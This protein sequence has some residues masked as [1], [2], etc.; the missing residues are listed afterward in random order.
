[1]LMIR[2]PDKI[3]VSISRK[4]FDWALRFP[5]I[6]RM[7]IPEI[8]ELYEHYLKESEEDKKKSQLPQGTE[9]EFPFFRLMELYHLEEF[10]L[11]HEGLR[12]LIPNIEGIQPREDFSAFFERLE[13]SISNGG[14]YYSIVVLYRDKAARFQHKPAREIRSLPEEVDY[15][16]VSLHKSLP[17]SMVIAFDV[18]LKGEVTDTLTALQQDSYFPRIQFHSLIPWKL[19]GYRF[20]QDPIKRIKTEKILFWIEGL[21]MG[22]ERSI[23]PYL[24][25]HFL[26]QGSSKISRLPAIEIYSLKGLTEEDESF[27]EWHKK[28]RNWW[29]SM[30]FNFFFNVFGNDKFIF[31][32]PEIHSSL[33]SKAYR[34]LVL[35]RQKGGKNENLL[36][37]KFCLDAFLPTIVLIEYFRVTTKSIEKLR[38]SVFVCM[39]KH[40]F[41]WFRLNRLITL[42]NTV[43]HESMI[44]ERFELEFKERKNII[45]HDL[46]SYNDIV[47]LKLSTDENEGQYLRGVLISTVLSRIAYLKNF[48]A[49]MKNSFSDFLSLKNMEALYSLQRRIFWLTVIIALV[50]ATSLIAS[51]DF[52]RQFLKSLLEAIINGII[53]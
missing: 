14:K 41:S 20:S 12:K 16:N 31:T 42:S 2:I 6:G 15:I 38:H 19:R 34:G 13:K 22:I 24:S 29:K 26:K 37:I 27:I 10:D 46:Q 11:L 51:N 25:G 36:D 49:L 44:H 48:F 33:S 47:M 43:M 3:R 40:G 4:Y 18:H 32:F 30:G 17:S 23:E 8:E 52:I 28:A 7:F 50:S 39:K 1:M 9:M 5:K 35:E 45:N 53:R 21:R